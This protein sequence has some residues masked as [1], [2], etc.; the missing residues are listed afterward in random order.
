MSV[1]LRNEMPGNYQALQ[2][3]VED[4]AQYIW[5]NIGELSLSRNFIWLQ[6]HQCRRY[7]SFRFR[8][9]IKF[10]IIIMLVGAFKQLKRVLGG[11]QI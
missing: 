1:D 10:Y 9:Q 6:L 7:K 3:Y 4:L 2:F 11:I 8:Y 5:R